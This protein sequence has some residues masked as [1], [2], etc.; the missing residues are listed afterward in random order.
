MS[1]EDPHS[2]PCGCPEAEPGEASPTCSARDYVSP[3]EVS[4]LADLRGVR[5]QVLAVKR[6]LAG[7]ASAL[8]PAEGAELEARLEELRRRHRSL[9]EDLRHANHEKLRRL[10]YVPSER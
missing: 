2:P 5:E 6:Q 8:P 7:P 9:R 4:I 1:Q 10:G 3:E